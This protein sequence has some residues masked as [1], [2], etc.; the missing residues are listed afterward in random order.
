MWVPSMAN[1]MYSVSICWETLDKSFI[2]SELQLPNLENENIR[3]TY[4][5]D[6]VE[7]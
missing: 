7:N 6:D 1:S 2:I 4:A 3:G 5:I